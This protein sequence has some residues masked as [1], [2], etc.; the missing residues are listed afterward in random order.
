[1]SYDIYKRVIGYGCDKQ[2][3]YTSISNNNC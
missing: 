3:P 2:I 1:L